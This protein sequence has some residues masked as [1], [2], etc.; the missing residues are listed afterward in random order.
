L[1]VRD[2]RFAPAPGPVIAIDGPAGSGKSAVSRQLATALGYAH[3]D[4]GALYRAVTWAALARG[5]RDG[6]EALA[7]LARGL[8]LDVDPHGTL[9]MNGVEVP[10]AALRSPEVTAR[11]SRVSAVPGV[12][13]ALLDVQR[14]LARR[15]PGLVAEGR[16]IGSVVFPEAAHSI[17]LD[18]SP[19]VRARRRAAQGEGGGASVEQIQAS[20]AERDRLDSGRAIAPLTQADGALRVD[21]SD[22]DLDQVVAHLRALIGRGVAQTLPA[23]RIPATESL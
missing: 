21:T 17:Y 16:D 3:L 15:V 20:L 10:D 1:V 9:V 11:V 7:E 13:A 6:D 18:A 4:S 2:E 19:E 5:T 14:G 8:N 22:M 12:R 23:S